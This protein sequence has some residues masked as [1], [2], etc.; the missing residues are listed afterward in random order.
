MKVPCQLSPP[1]FKNKENESQIDPKKIHTLPKRLFDDPRNI[2]TN[3]IK[4]QRR[5]LTIEEKRA[6]QEKKM[7]TT[8]ITLVPNLLIIRYI[9]EP[10]LKHK[11]P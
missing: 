3:K 7:V 4:T 9:H 6:A 8:H 5:Y 10:F 1:Y 11:D 2:I